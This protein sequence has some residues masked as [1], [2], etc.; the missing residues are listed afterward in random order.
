MGTLNEHNRWKFWEISEHFGQNFE[1]FYTG[2][3]NIMQ[4]NTVCINYLIFHKICRV[5]TNNCDHY[6]NVYICMWLDFGPFDTYL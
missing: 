1:H 5:L 3:Y 2:L 4:V 6:D